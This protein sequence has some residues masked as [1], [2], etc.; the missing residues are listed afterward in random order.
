MM[1]AH[2]DWRRRLRALT[3]PAISPETAAPCLAA[4]A[5]SLFLVLRDLTGI[6]LGFLRGRTT[7]WLCTGRRLCRANLVRGLVHFAGRVTLDG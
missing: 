2:L 3:Y 5:D 6:W 4:I 1:S 7:F